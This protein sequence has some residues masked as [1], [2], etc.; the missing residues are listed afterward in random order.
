MRGRGHG[1]EGQVLGPAAALSRHPLC[2]RL[3]CSVVSFQRGTRPP[4]SK[5][6]QQSRRGHMHGVKHRCT[7]IMVETALD[8]HRGNHRLDFFGA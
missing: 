7:L 5:N 2:N 8:V 1:G 3:E 4:P 6:K